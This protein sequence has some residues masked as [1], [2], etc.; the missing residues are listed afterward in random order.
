VSPDDVMD[1]MR[2]LAGHWPSPELGEDEVAVWMRTLSACELSTATEVIDGL[3]ASGR[4]WRPT[5]G[6]FLATYRQRM[7]RPKPTQPALMEPKASPE[8]VSR[9]LE[10]SRQVLGPV[11]RRSFY[12]N[13]D[14]MTDAEL[15][16]V[17]AQLTAEDEVWQSVQRKASEQLAPTTEE[18]AGK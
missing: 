12:N 9:N 18:D 1:A 17:A 2:L 8:S 4:A 7:S 13:G 5:D 3:A 10:K 15:Q 14:A 11:V 16:R 6:E